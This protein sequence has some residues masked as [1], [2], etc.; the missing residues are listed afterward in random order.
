LV[1]Y[2]YE[3]V[4]QPKRMTPIEKDGRSWKELV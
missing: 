4:E 3:G 1:R 2:L